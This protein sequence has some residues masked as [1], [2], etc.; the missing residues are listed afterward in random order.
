[1]RF[2]QQSW[3]VTEQALYFPSHCA[4]LAIYMKIKLNW[5]GN[6]AG[7]DPPIVEQNAAVH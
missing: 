6:R 5:E 3:M 2:H 7:K 4:A 1:M